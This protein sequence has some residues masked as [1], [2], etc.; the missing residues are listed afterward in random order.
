MKKIFMVL[1]LALCG[2]ALMAA[3]SLWD[4][5]LAYVSLQSGKK[6]QDVSVKT[7]DG[8]LLIA[9]TTEGDSVTYISVEI[10]VKPFVIGDKYLTMEI[11]GNDPKNTDCVYVRAQNSKRQNV[12]SFRNWNKPLTEDAKTY[13]FRPLTA[14]PTMP[15]EPQEIKAPVTD[16][17][18]RIAIF[19]GARGNGKP[20][21]IK[22]KNIALTENELPAFPIREG[23]KLSNYGDAALLSSVK[24]GNTVYLDTLPMTDKVTYNFT[25]IPFSGNL[26]GKKLVFTGSTATPAVTGAFYLRGYNS[27][28]ECILSYS[29]WGNVLKAEPQ[30]I[31]L[32]PGQSAHGLKWEADRVKA[33]AAQ[34]LVKLEFIVGTH[35]KKNQLMSAEF[36]DIQ[37]Q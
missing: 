28:K 25:S 36:K 5:D 14:Y 8:A 12:M 17:I 15:W 26:A 37:L 10:R 16:T 31:T 11:S 30:V 29:S 1:A 7:E 18:D 24:N 13:Y 21:S 4:G 33:G 34:D 2:T 22:V 27:K 35:K 6:L 23:E 19:I 20:I 9:G 32:T 3:T